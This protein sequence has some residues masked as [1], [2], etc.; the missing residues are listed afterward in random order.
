MIRYPQI[1]L[2]AQLAI[3]SYIL[4]RMTTLGLDPQAEKAQLKALI[5]ATVSH[6]SLVGAEVLET[7]SGPRVAVKIKGIKQSREIGDDE[8]IRAV[9]PEWFVLALILTIFGGHSH[10]KNISPRRKPVDPPPLP[11]THDSHYV[12]IFE[13]ARGF[14]WQHLIA[15][16]GRGQ[17]AQLGDHRILCM[18]EL[19]LAPRKGPWK[20]RA[21]AIDEALRLYQV[22]AD[23]AAAK[24]ATLGITKASYEA[25]LRAG[26]KLLDDC[27]GHKLK[28]DPGLSKEAAE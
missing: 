17:E 18:E 9:D 2:K 15:G 1:G 23:T 22:A 11:N 24:G 13:D 26:F 25:M 8:G 12:Y 7:P 4:R 3:A 16:A 27:H 21:T 20:E 28:L 19:T 5:K 10:I 6:G 14:T